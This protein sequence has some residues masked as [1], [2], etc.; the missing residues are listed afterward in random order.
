MTHI[1]RSSALLSTAELDLELG[2]LGAWRQDGDALVRDLRLVSFGAAI[3]CIND[4]A[5]LAEA[6]DHHPELRN[7]YRD[8]SVRLSTHD[9]GGITMKDVQLAT[10]IDQ[11]PG[12][13]G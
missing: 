2:R 8:L 10:A 1:D 9:A 11:L 6:A 3:D 5:E 7:V 13:E 4:I 12:L